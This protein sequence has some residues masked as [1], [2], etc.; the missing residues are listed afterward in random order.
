VNAWQVDL[1]AWEVVGLVLQL[2][3]KLI[4]AVALIL[5]RRPHAHGQ[6]LLP[7]LTRGWQRLHAA[8]GPR[9]DIRVAVGSGSG[10]VDWVGTARGYTPLTDDAPLDEQVTWLRNRVAELQAGD[11]ELRQLVDRARTNLAAQVSDVD[12][13]ARDRHEG[14]QRQVDRLGPAVRA[15]SCEGCSSSVSARCSARWAKVTSGEAPATPAGDSRRRV[16]AAQGGGRGRGR[17]RACPPV[18]ETAG[19]YS[20]AW[21]ARAAR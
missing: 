6:P 2:I 20:T 3:G 10:A 8:L 15:G 5:D 18:P 19:S 16:V 17:S 9:R 1:T 4:A 14:L 11:R 13:S 21:A 7:R 12:A